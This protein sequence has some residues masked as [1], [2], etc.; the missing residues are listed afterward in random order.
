MI[1][2]SD[3]EP[4]LPSCFFVFFF[5]LL[6][7]KCMCSPLFN[8]YSFF[9]TI[10]ILN[11]W[12][13][14]TPYHTCPN[15]WKKPMLLLFI[16]SKNW[17]LSGK[18]FRHWNW[19]VVWSGSMLFAIPLSILSNRCIKKQNIG[20]NSWNKVLEILGHLPYPNYL[21]YRYL[22]P[23]SLPNQY[24]KHAWAHSVDPHLWHLIGIYTV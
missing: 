22:Y 21:G 11:N 3:I 19:G 13:T 9:H 17:M 6:S 24:A 23:S 1:Q 15:D 8:F 7:A 2:V 18:Q 4:S 12:D 16:V 5:N 20:H 14:W 10:F